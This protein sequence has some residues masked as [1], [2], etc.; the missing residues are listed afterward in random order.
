VDKRHKNAPWRGPR[1]SVLK[2]ALV[3][4]MNPTGFIVGLSHQLAQPPQPRHDLQN[5]L[6]MWVVPL[7]TTT[8]PTLFSKSFSP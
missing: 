1:G 3:A 4:A 8:S 2:E 7:G 5:R 6:A